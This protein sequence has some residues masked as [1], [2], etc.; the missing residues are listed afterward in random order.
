MTATSVTSAS[1]F[2][3]RAARI[4]C[5]ARCDEYAVSHGII[6]RGEA[7]TKVDGFVLRTPFDR[8]V[9]CPFL[10]VVA[11]NVNMAGQTTNIEPSYGLN[12]LKP[13]VS[14]PTIGHQERPKVRR[15][16]LFQPF[17]KSL[18]HTRKRCHTNI[19]LSVLPEAT[20]GR[21]KSM[22]LPIGCAFR[23]LSRPA[24]PVPHGRSRRRTHRR[25]RGRTVVQPC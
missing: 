11:L 23:L 2:L 13:W 1:F 7:Q 21:S 3:G 19:E 14:I 5:E 17:K 8:I 10:M 16:N 22:T 20:F 12:Y 9:S 25:C 4:L 6:F 15:E 18:F 24:C